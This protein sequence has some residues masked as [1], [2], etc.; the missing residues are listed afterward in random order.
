M[1]LVPEIQESALRNAAH[2]R[3]GSALMHLHGIR[4]EKLTEHLRWPPAP[5][6]GGYLLSRSP[7]RA[8]LSATRRAI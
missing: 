2:R 3:I 4:S 7:V 1:G 5:I 6:R 8:P